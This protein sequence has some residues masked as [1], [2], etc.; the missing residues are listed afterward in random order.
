M[1]RFEPSELITTNTG[2]IYH[3]DISPDQLADDVILVG[4][5]GRVEEI[6]SLFD[7]IEHEVSNREFV[8]HTG[9]IANKRL[10]VLSTGIGTDN[11]DI[12]VNELDALVNID[13]ENRREKTVKKSLNLIR[14]G[15]SGALHSSLDVDSF[16]ISRYGMG[17]DNLAT[18]YQIDDKIIDKAASEAFI[19]HS[20]WPKNRSEPYFVR[21]SG[22]L[23]NLFPQ[24]IQRGI[25]VT[26]P[27][28]YGPQGRQL[29]IET[30]DKAQNQ[31]LATF[32]WNNIPVTNY[33]METSALYALGQQ[34]GHK[35]LTIC[36]II[37]NREAGAY[38]KDHKKAV[39]N[40]INYVI[41]T[42]TK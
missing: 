18:F 16:V 4:D 42:L 20:L 2:H 9:H 28:F 37:A 31:N 36:A 5:P 17:I 27:G 38:S 19:R 12:V 40:L 30:S 6:S 23:D 35:T 29:R 1:K 21:N 26:A 7:F 22:E 41:E 32:Q 11:I 3:L 15:T 14:L 24:S 10:T 33:E 8:T 39:K 34:L 13:L 25:T